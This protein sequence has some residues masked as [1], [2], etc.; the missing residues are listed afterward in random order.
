MSV[1]EKI[2]A[3]LGLGSKRGALLYYGSSQ[4]L[5]PGQVVLPVAPSHGGVLVSHWPDSAALTPHD[6]GAHRA[7]GCGPVWVYEVEPLGSV[8]VYRRSDDVIVSGVAP[9]V[10][11]VALHKFYKKPCSSP[12]G[13]H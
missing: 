6:W 8:E 1:L 12:T 3:F 10:R 11:V 7:R 9:K 13:G 4:A 2:R 5:E